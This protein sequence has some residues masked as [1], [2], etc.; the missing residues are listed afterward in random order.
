MSVL[1]W[2]MALLIVSLLIQLI[3]WKIKVPKRQT[4]TVLCIFFL[5]MISGLLVIGAIADRLNILAIKSFSEYFHVSLFF[6]SLTL[7]YMITYSAIEVDSP[8]LVMINTIAKAG[9]EGLDQ[10]L[11]IQ[12]MNDD[13]LVKPRITDLLNDKM[14]YYNGDKYRLTL[15]GI[16]FARLFVFYRKLL[17]APKGG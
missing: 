8:S 6:I 1:V 9:P 12:M 5:V 4:K 11:F 17:N 10:K 3:V 16:L 7:A 15:K 2:S 14:A 13:L